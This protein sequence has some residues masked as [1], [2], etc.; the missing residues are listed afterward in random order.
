[1]SP[2]LGKE[3]AQGY[4]IPRGIIND[5]IKEEDVNKVEVTVEACTGHGRSCSDVLGDDVVILP[6]HVMTSLMVCERHVPMC[7]CVDP[8][9]HHVGS[10]W[11][12]D[13]S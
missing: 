6:V 3:E 1:V 2:F 5:D 7:G 4:M 11:S 8:C 13:R 12:V 10:C 9:R